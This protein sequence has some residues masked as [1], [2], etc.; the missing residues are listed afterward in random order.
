MIRKLRECPFFVLSMPR[1]GSTALLHYF[2]QHY[3]A[4]DPS[5][6]GC[7][8][9]YFDVE[10]QRFPMLNDDGRIHF[11]QTPPPS[12]DDASLARQIELK[13]R[14]EMLKSC[15]LRDT[16]HLFKCLSV[17]IHDA[18]DLLLFLKNHYGV[19]TLERRNEFKMFVSFVRAVR[20]GEWHIEGAARDS[21]KNLP[22]AAHRIDFLEFVYW[23]RHYL[24]TYQKLKEFFAPCL[25]R[26][27]YYEDF[28][29]DF[30][31]LNPLFGFVGQYDP[32]RNPCQRD[33]AGDLSWISNLEEVRSWFDADN[34]ARLALFGSKESQAISGLN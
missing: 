30:N 3:Q 18:P 12:L 15:L 28:C 33:R 14:A 4:N 31:K 20:T 22:P 2:I 23:I 29:D 16:H 10:N 11:V 7:L 5:F 8:W 1:T 32:H 19:I 17:Q 34:K 24:L 26:T 13:R 21:Y 25:L 6:G 27:I 9:E